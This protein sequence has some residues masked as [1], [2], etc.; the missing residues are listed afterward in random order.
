M[1]NNV[2]QVF[3]ENNS[4]GCIEFIADKEI[5]EKC[6]DIKALGAIAKHISEEDSFCLYGA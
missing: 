3:L 5:I 2:T 4:R 1:G 6:L